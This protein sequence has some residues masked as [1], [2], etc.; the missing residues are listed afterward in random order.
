[1]S[2]VFLTLFTLFWTS[3]VLG[4]DG[5]MGHGIYKQFEAGHYPSVMGTITRSEVKSH[6]SSKGA[7]SYSAVIEYSFAVGDRKFAGDKIRFGLPASSYATGWGLVNAH[8]VGS[9]ARVFYKETNPRESLLLPGVQGPDLM[10]PLFMTPFNMVMFGFWMGIGGWLR[11]H[12]FKPAAGGVKIITDGLVTRIRLPRFPALGR[13]LA[14]TGGLGF[15][16]IFIVGFSTNMEPS[17]PVALA[18][19]AAVYGTGL[20]V[21]WRQ[22]QKIDS[23]I[24]DLLFN[25]ASRSLELPLTFGRKARITANVADI[26]SLYVEQIVHSSSKGGISHTYAPTL[27]LRG[28]EPG[29]QKIVEWSDPLKADEFT[30]WLRRRLGAGIPARVFRFEFIIWRY[31]PGIVLGRRG[32]YRGIPAGIVPEG[33]RRGSAAGRCAGAPGWPADWDCGS[34]NDLLPSIRRGANDCGF[35]PRPSVRGSRPATAGADAP[36]AARWTGNTV[37]RWWWPRFF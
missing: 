11:R 18:G 2:A 23:G 25:E 22:R 14:A 16:A 36:G 30:G 10:G 12:W 26:E 37:T 34:A 29:A 24:D 28:G 3:M 27:R 5:F 35:R 33:A 8:P 19:I 7:T 9:P 32:G 17:M 1:M 15:M 4:F 21:Y 6:R 20:G 31:G 13:G